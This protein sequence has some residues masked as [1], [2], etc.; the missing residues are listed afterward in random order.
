MLKVT[1]IHECVCTT[2]KY[3]NEWS[4]CQISLLYH[5]LFVWNGGGLDDYRGPMSEVFGCSMWTRGCSS[6]IWVFPLLSC[7]V[8]IGHKLSSLG[9][10]WIF[11]QIIYFNDQ[12]VWTGRSI[13]WFYVQDMRHNLLY[14][15]FR[16]FEDPSSFLFVFR[17][18]DSFQVCHQ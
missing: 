14:F 1:C 2:R 10:R 16:Y 12:A 11:I 18:R 8:L 13:S 9:D 15:F 4:S 17:K 3:Y 5:K 7:Y 6:W